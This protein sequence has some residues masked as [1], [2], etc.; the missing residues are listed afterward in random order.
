[1]VAHAKSELPNEC[2]GMLAGLREGN[3]LRV[4][5]WFPLVNEAKSPVEYLSDP[6]SMFAADKE[7]RR[8]GLEF[9][10]TYHSH[11]TSAPI[12][13]RTDLARTY[14]DDV[15]N[16][17]ISMSGPEPEMRGWWLTLESFD[18]ANWSLID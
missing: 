16:F 7:R 1:M 2:C 13:S 12:P 3:V 11:P 17:I 8:L 10:A 18:E 6:R 9:V 14:S 15:V 5:A 4:Q